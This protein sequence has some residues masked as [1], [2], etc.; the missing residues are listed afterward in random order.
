M[1]Y[2]KLFFLSLSSIVTIFCGCPQTVNSSLR[3][4]ADF[5]ILFSHDTSNVT[6][7]I[8]PYNNEWPIPESSDYTVKIVYLELA[9]TAY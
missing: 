6:S 1:D 9:M 8:S 5:R 7:C 3:P 4:K 2:R